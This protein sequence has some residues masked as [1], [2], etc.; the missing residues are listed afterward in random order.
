MVLLNSL[1]DILVRC[2]VILSFS[3][4]VIYSENGCDVMGENDMSMEEA[5]ND[6]FRI[7][8]YQ[9][10]LAA[11][12]RAIKEGVPGGSPPHL[13]PPLVHTYTLTHSLFPPP[14]PSP[15]P[16]TDTHPSPSPPSTLHPSSDTLPF[17]LVNTIYP[18]YPQPF[19]THSI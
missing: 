6:Q 9:Q 2:F 1:Y 18:N 11:M 8:Y 14:H 5:L 10:Y 13:T 19:I 16:L 7:T 17:T 12:D 15:T 4:F 3:L